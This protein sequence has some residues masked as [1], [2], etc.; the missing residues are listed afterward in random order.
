MRFRFQATGRALLAALALAALPG[1]GASVGTVRLPKGEGD[2]ANGKEL[3]EARNYA[4]A[5]LTLKGF[6]DANPAGNQAEEASYLLGMSYF[7]S[8]QFPLAEVELRHLIDLYP[9]SPHV[10]EVEFRLAQCYWED[11]RPAAYDPEKTLFAQTQLSRFLVLYPQ[12]PFVAEAKTL[13]AEVN[14]RL[15]EK[16]VINA[17]L[18]LKLHQPAS[19]V[20]YADRVLTEFPES[21]W[22]SEAHFLKGEGM[23]AQGKREQARAEWNLLVEK[24]PGSAWAD[25]AREALAGIPAQA[26]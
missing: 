22:V 25:R 17:R 6:L 21:A 24:N 19:T 11:A 13:Q 18:Y 20:F 2:F 26:P 5:A 8:S 4:E 15:A 7:K 9:G 10:D 3:Y 1:C 23:L 14:G 16:A 12:S